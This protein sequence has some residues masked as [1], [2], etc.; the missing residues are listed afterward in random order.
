RRPAAAARLL[1]RALRLSV[2]GEH[3]RAVDDNAVEPVALRPVGKVLARVLEVRRG[4]VGPL[5]VVADEDDRQLADAGDVHCLVRVPARGGAL[6]VPTARDT[7][8]AEQILPVETRLLDLT[9]RADRLGF[10]NR[11]CRRM[12]TTRRADESGRSGS[13]RTAIGCGR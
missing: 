9:Q 10:T 12:L 4:R 1:D 5:V 7:V 11:H 6:A 3:V 2:N 13:A 8:D